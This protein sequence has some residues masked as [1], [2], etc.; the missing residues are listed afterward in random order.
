VT[1]VKNNKEY[2]TIDDILNCVW[3]L[4]TQIG[5]TMSAG[6]HLLSIAKE[7][8]TAPTIKK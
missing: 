1:I 6:S 8:N 5:K 7:V 2:F 4:R 3:A